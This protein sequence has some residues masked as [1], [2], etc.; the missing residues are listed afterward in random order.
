M[1]KR[2]ICSF[3]G[4]R[5][6][7]MQQSLSASNYQID[8]IRFALESLLAKKI[9]EGFNVFQCG[10]ALGADTLFAEEVI[11]LKRSNPEIRLNAIIP[12]PHQENKWFGGERVKY[13]KL[14][15]YADRLIYTSDRYYDGC[16]HARNRYLV[17]SCNEL[18]AIYD[19]KKGGSDFTIKYA[20]KKNVK[21]TVINPRKCCV[22]YLA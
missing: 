7:K 9:A 4:Y 18:I 3:T 15:K 22:V 5:T 11:R 19:G 14:L 10:M 20:Q 2:L 13:Y 17:D 12:C 21:V 1:K 16:M 6:F 8:D